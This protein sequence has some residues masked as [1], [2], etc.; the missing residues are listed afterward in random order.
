MC[1]ILQTQNILM[2]SNEAME[3][4][5]G[6]PFVGRWCFKGNLISDE[7]VA[8]CFVLTWTHVAI[9]WY[10]LRL[11]CLMSAQLLC[12]GWGEGTDLCLLGF[13]QAH[14]PKQAAERNKKGIC[15]NGKIWRQIVLLLWP[16]LSGVPFVKL[17]YLHIYF[18]GAGRAVDFFEQAISDDNCQHISH[19][20]NEH[21]LWYSWERSRF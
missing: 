13:E 6:F 16:K 4:C 19:Q 17:F 14:L 18:C 7:P 5:E 12:A 20:G 1:L 3:S 10:Q 9:N 11:L 21:L 8:E 2:C 15:F